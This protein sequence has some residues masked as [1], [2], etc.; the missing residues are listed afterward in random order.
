MRTLSRLASPIAHFLSVSAE[1]VLRLVG[2]GRPEEPAVTEEEIKIMIE[3]GTQLGVF[4]PIEEE[5]VERV[6]RLGDRKI[7]SLLTPR[8]DIIWLNVDD[9]PEEIQRTL[10]TSS[11][12]RYPVAR[13]SLDNVLGLVL[14][15]DLLAQSLA[16]QPPDPQAVIRPAPFVPES[17]PALDVLERFREAG[18][19][20]ALVVDEYGGLQGLVTAEDILTAIVGDIPGL[21]E[22]EEPEAYQREDGSWLVDGMLPLDDFQ[23]LF[24][25]EEELPAQGVDTLGGFVMKRLDRIPSTGDAFELQGL[26]FEVVDM[27]KHRVDKIQVTPTGTTRPATPCG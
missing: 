10:A 4:E 16:D 12:S 27:D 26:H 23:E 24:D 6:F 25:L 2:V 13:G 17:M 1:A 11:H 21:G 7:S 22:I 19:K 14:V 8:P 3:L 9:P 20:I 15:K 18:S 5:M